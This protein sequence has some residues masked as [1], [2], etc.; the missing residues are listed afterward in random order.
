MTMQGI[1]ISG[2]QAGIDLGS[3]PCDFAIVKATEGTGYVNP[4]CD[5][6]VQQ[7]IEL[8]KQGRMVLGHRVVSFCE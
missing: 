2:W 1:D 3:V 4:D 6:A 5:R 7:C 8:G